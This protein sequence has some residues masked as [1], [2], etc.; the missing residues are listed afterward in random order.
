MYIIDGNNYG[1][2]YNEQNQKNIRYLVNHGHQ[3]ASHTW[4]HSHL[5]TLSW[6]QC[7]YI[8][9]S[10]RFISNFVFSPL[11][12]DTMYKTEQA[13]LRIAGV[14]PAFMRPPYGEINDQVV[15]VAK[16]RG[17]KVVIWDFDSGDSIGYTVGQSEAEYDKV[18]RKHPNTILTL[19]HETHG[20]Y[21]SF[22]FLWLNVQSSILTHFNL[23]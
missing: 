4:E 14:K 1:C 17:Q 22:T 16:I 15:E 23:F 20:T 5:P 18:V 8:I 12:H 9:S 2:I 6:D 19:N 11:V 3:V 13:I 21:P 7:M 10:I